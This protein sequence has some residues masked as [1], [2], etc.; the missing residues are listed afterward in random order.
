M[1]HL[2]AW[3]KAE[4][5]RLSALARFLGV[6]PT[7]INNWEK[8]PAERMGMVSGFTGIPMRDLRSDIFKVAATE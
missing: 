8:V 5:G 3:I 2:R 6:T 4:R 1:K 7:A